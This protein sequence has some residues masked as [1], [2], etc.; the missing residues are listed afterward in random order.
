MN[1]ARLNI[2]LFSHI[3][4][5]THITGAEKLLLFFAT[6][7]KGNHQCTLVVPNE[8]LLS[9]EA[10][11]RGIPTLVV[12]YPNFYELYAPGPYFQ[13]ALDGFLQDGKSSL[14]SVMKLLL[15]HRPDVVISNTC[16]NL[17]PVWAARVLGIPVGWMITEQIQSNRYTG[18]SIAMI[19]GN[20]DWIIGI[21]DATMQPFRGN[22]AEGKIR[23]M[24]PSWNESEL[25]REGWPAY[26]SLKRQEIGW[27]DKAQVV[28]YVTSDIYPN[29]GLEH[30]IQMAI[31]L[32]PLHPEVCYLV[33]GKVTDEVYYNKC[34]EQIRSAGLASRFYIHPFEMQIQKLYPAI[35][36]LVISSLIEEGF[37]MTAL[38]GLIFGKAVVSY[39]AGGLNE[40][41]HLTGNSSFLVEKGNVQEL[42]KVTS[43]LLVKGDE[44]RAWGERNS[45]VVENAFGIGSYRN[46]V[47]EWLN[48]AA[49]A[50]PALGPAPLPREALLR[51]PP[52]MARGSGPAVYLLERG[53]RYMF[54]DEAAFRRRGGAFERVLTLEQGHLVTLP[55]GPELDGL[56]VQPAVTSRRKRR[57]VKGKRKMKRWGRKNMQLKAHRKKGKGLLKARRVRLR[58]A[59]RKAGAKRRSGRSTIRRKVRKAGR[60][61]RS[62]RLGKKRKA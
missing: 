53:Y 28:G 6:E 5:S 51:R 35:D 15:E 33:A 10:R 45:T 40:I 31:Q 11:A 32:A 14:E 19:A 57:R 50:L 58:R 37:G 49:Q 24:Y 4:S 1:A 44:L 55:S 7:L 23:I 48:Q 30:F 13:D 46:R 25:E 2:M 54:S 62:G 27:N 38:E 56:P 18:H 20:A 36:L 42:A 17:M 43:S 41:L 52:L 21:S 29:K 12:S 39:S 8:G 61:R 16:V 59:A 34:Q 9:T 22:G 47:S 3:C 60:T 26:R